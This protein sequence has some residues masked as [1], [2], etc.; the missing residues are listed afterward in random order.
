M[1]A[2]WEALFEGRD[3]EL[4]QLRNMWTKAKTGEPQLALILGET[5][6]GKT[7]LVQELFAYL[8]KDETEDPEGYWPA[9]LK[10]GK[11]LAYNAPHELINPEKTMPWLWWGL[12]FSAPSDRNSSRIVSP[13]EQ[14]SPDLMVHVDP[15]LRLRGRKELNKEVAK[16]F[17]GLL[18]DI[19][20]AGLYGQC[21][22]VWEMWNKRR[23]EQRLRDLSVE[24]WHLEH[25]RALTERVVSNTI[26]L[27]YT[28]F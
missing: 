16:T 18:A 13:F 28:R 21:Y 2:D 15:I 22:G 7:R 19:A 26:V 20:G 27:F 4:S 12:R 9:A 11:D 23:E 1:N 8:S 6:L 5:G 10:Q 17:V 3:S 25:I 24:A 14:E